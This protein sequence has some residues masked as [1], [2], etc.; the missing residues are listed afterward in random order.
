MADMTKRRWWMGALLGVGVGMGLVGGWDVAYSQ[1][2]QAAGQAT[3]QAAGQ[4]G[5]AVRTLKPGEIEVQA[6]RVYVFVGKTGL[7]HDHGIEGR[8]RS[9]QLNLGAK[10]KAGRLE[11]DLRTFVAD[12]AAA[13]QYVGLGGQTDRK[14]ADK[15]TA[16]MQS[17][18]VLD[19]AR[20]PIATFD[21]GSIVALP[22][23]GNQPQQYQLTGDFTLHGV[24]RQIRFNAQGEP[25]QGF[26]RLRGNFSIRQTDFG[27]TPYTQALGAVGV[28]DQLT[29]HGDLYVMAGE[30]GE[31]AG[32][33]TA[34]KPETTPP[35]RR[36]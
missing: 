10:E 23:R 29:I 35:A 3:G 5:A 33:S 4:R 31:G 12:T 26:T 18:A 34:E 28:A 11:F 7:G 1:A 13:R 15:V 32:S 17:A 16:N 25:V 2:Q 6:S 14:T 8:L 24:K 19:V 20:F 27:I 22:R 9:G 36:Q 30:V 21:L